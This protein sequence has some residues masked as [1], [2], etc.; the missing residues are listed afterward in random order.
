MPVP[1]DRRPDAWKAAFHRLVLTAGRHPVRRTIDKKKERAKEL[2]AGKKKQKA[3]H[4]A[5][6]V[7]PAVKIPCC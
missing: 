4:H 1:L 5:V 3:C 7:L 6:V 2:S